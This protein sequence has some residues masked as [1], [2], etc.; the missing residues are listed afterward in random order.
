MPF[1]SGA[2]A[3]NYLSVSLHFG[4]PLEV[5]G[6]YFFGCEAPFLNETF[7]YR[8]ERCTFAGHRLDYLSVIFLHVRPAVGNCF[9]GRT[10]DGCP[11][12][13]GE[14]GIPILVSD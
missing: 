5:S 7:L 13:A 14:G 12:R 9:T 4:E 11:L 10:L 8:V 2:I 1:S 3:K 6:A